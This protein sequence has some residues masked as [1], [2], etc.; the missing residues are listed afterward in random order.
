MMLMEHPG[1]LTQRGDVLGVPRPIRGRARP[2]LRAPDV[3]SQ[4]QALCTKRFWPLTHKYL[5]PVCWALGMQPLQD[6]G[7]TCPQGTLNLTEEGGK[8]HRVRADERRGCWKPRGPDDG[9]ARP[10]AGKLLS[11]SGTRVTQ[12]GHLVGKP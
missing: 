11:S 12:V 3:S 4:A 7:T 1:T 6:T 2:K 5:P 8:R 10:Y 9:P